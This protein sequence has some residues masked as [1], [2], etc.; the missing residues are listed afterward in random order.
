MKHS[1]VSWVRSVEVDMKA[2]Q[3]QAEAA[4]ETS[5]RLRDAE[6]ASARG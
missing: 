2:G 4:E 6:A 3:D 5:G 1:P